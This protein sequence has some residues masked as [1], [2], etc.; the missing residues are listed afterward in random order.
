M[1]IV[2]VGSTDT[3]DTSVLHVRTSTSSSPE[4]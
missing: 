4:T 3:V 1:V 2:E